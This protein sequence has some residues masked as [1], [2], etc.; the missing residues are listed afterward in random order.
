MNVAI[1]PARGGSTRVPRKNVRPFFGKPILAYSIETALASGLFDAV[2]VSTDD[3]EI[4]R[5]AAQYGAPWLHR[6]AEYAQD[7]VGTQAVMRETLLSLE[8]GKLDSVSYREPFTHAC[9]IYATV[10]MLTTG[11]LREGFRLL[12]K[13]VARFAF[14]VGSEPLRDAGMFY[15]GTARSFTEGYPHVSAESVMVPIP[16]E[17]ICDINEESDFLR[18]ERMYA[19]LHGQKDNG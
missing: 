19:A 1:I 4:G 13:R 16:E 9:C 11:D 5:I 18:A 8:D 12:K 15:W 6:R 14:S 3:D 17:R 2:F 10:P 7:Q